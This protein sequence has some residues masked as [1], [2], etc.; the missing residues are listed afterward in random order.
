MPAIGRFLS[1]LK[2]TVALLVLLAVLLGGATWMSGY[3][4]TVG[5]LRRDFYGSWWFNAILGLLA[6]N[7][8][9]CTVKRKP[10]AFWQRGFL[11]THLGVLVVLVASAISF[12]W[13]V[14]GD[15]VVAEGSRTSRMELEGERELVLRTGQGEQRFDLAVNPYVRSRP[16]RAWPVPGHSHA[17]HLEEYLPNVGDQGAFENVS[18]GTLDV[19]ELRTHLDTRPLDTMYLEAG[20]PVRGELIG[21]AFLKDAA[22]LQANLSGPPGLRLEIAG[23]A[24]DLGLDAPPARVGGRDVAIRRFYRSFAVREDGEPEDLPGAESN[25]AV[26][27]EIGGETFFAFALYPQM[28]P[29]RKGSGPHDRRPDFRAFLRYAPRV[30]MLWFFDV[31]GALSYV[32]TTAS[33]QRQA[34]PV[35]AGE[36]IRH[37]TMPMGLFFEIARRLEHAEPTLVEAPPKKGTPA[38]PAVR[39]RLGEGP[40]T[41]IRFGEAASIGD[42][43]VGFGPKTAKDF[44]LV[45]ELAKFHHPPHEGTDRA[46]RFESE[47][48]IFDPESGRVFSGR[49]GVNSPVSFGGWTFYQS[50]YNDKV[51]PVVS[52][53]QVSHDPG[54]RPLYL[55]F[56]MIASG[57]L[58]MMTIKRRLLQE[59]KDARE[60]RVG[61]LVFACAGTILGGALAPFVENGLLLGGGMVLID[62]AAAAIALRVRVGREVAAAWCVNTA[63]LVALMWMR[64]PA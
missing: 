27:F 37:P 9:A 7:L 32:L 45:V 8:I 61:W 34:G 23:E 1:S 24:A 11:I 58:F 49:V 4:I 44:R 10:W 46:S 13:K 52:I 25:P 12:N 20:R 40:S 16:D 54:K 53:L 17:L 48:R 38:V 62:A 39:V 21:F 60:S 18:G 36:R 43:A 51:R 28:G 14:Y 6:V 59:V 2:L 50:G 47:L 26:E 19:L 31:D 5:A 22:D 63:A 30:S 29:V 35:R 15:L 33:G 56:L 57:T 55:G 64:V 41:W 3:D 42:V